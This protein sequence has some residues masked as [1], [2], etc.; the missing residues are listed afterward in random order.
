M[1]YI[2]IAIGIVIVSYLLFG[3]SSKNTIT[4]SKELLNVISVAEGSQDSLKVSVFSYNTLARIY[5]NYQNVPEEYRDFRFRI[6]KIVRF[7]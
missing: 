4:A 5:E 6:N 3:K 1:M 7:T 2:W